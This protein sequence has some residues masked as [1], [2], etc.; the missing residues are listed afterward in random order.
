MCVFVWISWLHLN[1][2]NRR[3]RERDRSSYSLLKTKKALAFSWQLK[4]CHGTVHRLCTLSS[5][6]CSPEPLFSSP[7]IPSFLSTFICFSFFT[8]QHEMV[9]KRKE[10]D[11]RRRALG[12]LHT[13]LLL[14][15][16]L[17]TSKTMHYY[18][19]AWRERICLYPFRALSSWFSL[20]CSTRATIKWGG[21]IIVWQRGKVHIISDKTEKGGSL[22]A[23]TIKKKS[24][25]N[26]VVVPSFCY[27]EN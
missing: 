15:L 5:V 13:L 11:L 12:P 27:A 2:I 21:I 9:K 24:Q 16:L 18:L 26:N 20:D 25:D 3:R 19:V 10:K 8:V 17:F 6:C 4:F 14:I 22:L 23:G 1:R 7:S